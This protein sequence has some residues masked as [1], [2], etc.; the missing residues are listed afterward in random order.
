MKISLTCPK[1]NYNG[2][3]IVPRYLVEVQDNGVYKMTC[4]AGHET[5]T[6]L[7]EQK[8]EILFDLAL[9]AILD[10]YYREGVVNFASSLERFYEF[11]IN[12]ISIKRD[13]DQKK[14]QEAVN[15]VTKQS[16]R[17]LG[18]YIFVYLLENGTLPKLLTEN[19]QVKFRNDV[20]HNG[21][22]PTRQEA[23]DFGQAVLDIIVPVLSKLNEY[24]RDHVDAAVSSHLNKTMQHIKGKPSLCFMSISTTIRINRT[25]NK[26]FLSVK[27]ALSRIEKRRINP[28]ISIKS[29]NNQ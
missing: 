11:Y 19:S 1:C 17:Q 24:E 4:N 6:C 21:K 29:K 7:Q 12:V 14:Y 23:I 3:A 9:Y 18:A 22:I 5:V 28:L 27:D 8:F 2:K 25:N 26:E 10:G 15:K 16:E 20:V 13:I